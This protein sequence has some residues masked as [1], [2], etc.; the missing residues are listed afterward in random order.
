[1]IAIGTQPRTPPRAARLGAALLGAVLAIGLGGCN[2][3]GAPSGSPLSDSAFQVEWLSADVP[4]KMKP[5]ETATVNVKFR[6]I[7]DQVWPDPKTADPA[8]T[9]AYAVRL[10]WRWRT[11]ED[12]GSGEGTSYRTDLT[13]PLGPGRETTLA[14]NVTAPKQPGQYRLQIDLVQELVAYFGDRGAKLEIIPVD[15]Q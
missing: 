9:G 10:A 15:V 8:A 4:A 3:G 11:S 7:S 13:E 2:Q 5:G 14:T 1:M 6:N 12:M